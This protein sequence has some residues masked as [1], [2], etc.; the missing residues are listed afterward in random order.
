MKNIFLPIFLFI[1]FFASCNSGPI[2]SIDELTKLEIQ[3]EYSKCLGIYTAD[4]NAIQ[5]NMANFVSITFALD[6]IQ[7]DNHQYSITIDNF[8]WTENENREKEFKIEIPEFAI[9]YIDWKSEDQIEITSDINEH[10][11]VVSYYKLVEDN[12]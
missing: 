7:I 8:R 4:A 11:S 5:Y 2:D 10:K 6:N 3:E 1:F 12:K 9:L